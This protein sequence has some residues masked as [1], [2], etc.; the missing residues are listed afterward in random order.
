MTDWYK[1]KRWLIRV[2]GVE[3]QFYPASRLPSA[4][5]EVEYIESS[6]TQYINTGIEKKITNVIRY[7][8]EF[9]YADT[10]TR[11]LNGSAGLYYVGV[12]NG[13]YQIAQGGQVYTNVPAP[14]NTFVDFDITLPMNTDLPM[15]ELLK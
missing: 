4:Y 11:Q 9:S 6:G 3:K 12:L 1:I 7:V 15:C 2:N 5:Q 10:Q 8:G 14:T 13:Y